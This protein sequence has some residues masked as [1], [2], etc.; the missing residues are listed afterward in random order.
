MNYNYSGH[1]SSLYYVLRTISF[2]NEIIKHVKKYIPK[3]Y[4]TPLNV[5][6]KCQMDVKFI[7]N[8][9]NTNKRDE[10]GYYQYTV[11]DEASRKRFIYPYKEHSS[12]STCDFIG[13][14]INF[15]GYKPKCIQT[16]NRFEFT[17]FNEI[18]RIIPWINF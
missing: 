7:T 9:C 17:Y 14:A 16:D 13:K 8:D 4:H 6:K 1:F 12:Y 5:D 2:Y 18:K 10:F 11:I 3:P 15:F